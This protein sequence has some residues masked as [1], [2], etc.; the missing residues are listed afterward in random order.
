MTTTW[1][2]AKTQ[3]GPWTGTFRSRNEA[4]IAGKR[5]FGETVFVVG[6][7]R[8]PDA[9]D[10]VPDADALLDIAKEIAFEKHGD[11]AVEWPKPIDPRFE[12][13]EKERLVHFLRTWFRVN[14][15]CTFWV[16]TG[17]VEEIPP[18]VEL[19]DP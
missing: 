13:R 19:L 1:C 7:G 5:A 18:L 8:L 3:A 12:E 14:Y 9:A 11:E 6:E 4:L 16:R 17:V 15:P 2:Y 10:F